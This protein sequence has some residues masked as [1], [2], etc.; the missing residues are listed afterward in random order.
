MA[1]TLPPPIARLFAEPN[2]GHIATVMPDGSPQVTPVWVDTDGHHVIVNTAEGRQKTR[3]LR[4]GSK[5]AIS[6]ADRAVPTRWAAVRGRV[7]ELTHDG[8]EEHIN[9]LALKYT[10]RAFG[11]LPA[12][13]QRVI[14]KILPEHVSGPGAG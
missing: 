2:I 9:R 4:R 3:N 1:A 10:G 6:V 7:A 13:Q 11:R 8:A 12:G 14:V 5:V